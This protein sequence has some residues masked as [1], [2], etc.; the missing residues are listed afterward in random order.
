MTPQRVPC[1]CPDCPNY[2]M[3]ADGSTP[4]LVYFCPPCNALVHQADLERMADAYGAN[5]EQEIVTR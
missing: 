4:P 3:L 2:L 1:E 5:D